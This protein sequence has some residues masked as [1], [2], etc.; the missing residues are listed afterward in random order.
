MERNMTVRSDSSWA[1]RLRCSSAAFL[2][3]GALARADSAGAL[4]ALAMD[5]CCACAC[6]LSTLPADL[7]TVSR[8][9]CAARAPTRLIMY[10]RLI[11]RLLFL[12]SL[13]LALVVVLT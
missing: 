5:C 7:P 12:F 4:P 11:D 6:A 13:G 10:L 3:S 9:A 8:T 1:A 2:A